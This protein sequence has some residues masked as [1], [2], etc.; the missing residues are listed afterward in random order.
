MVLSGHATGVTRSQ[1]THAFK[2]RFPKMHF[3]MGPAMGSREATSVGYS[4][5][6]IYVKPLQFQRTLSLT[7]Q[8]M[9]QGG[10][11]IGAF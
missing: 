6:V 1:A 3:L 8:A 10:R 2:L 7:M 11:A 5:T 9:G 4:K